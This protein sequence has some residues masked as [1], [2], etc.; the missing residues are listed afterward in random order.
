MRTIVTIVVALFAVVGM[1]FFT[2]FLPYVALFLA[3]AVVVLL[4]AI[5]LAGYYIF[6]KMVDA[7]L[8]WT[9]VETGWCKIILKW[10]DYKRTIGPGL[11]FIGI[12]GIYTLYRR[13][14]TFLKSV[15]DKEGRPQAE[16]HEDRDISSFKTTDYAYAFPFKDE[17]DS[18]GLHLSGM[19]AVIAILEDYWKAFFVAS[20]W[21]SI[22]NSEIM[23]C[24]RDVLVEI[25][26]DDELVGRDTSEERDRKT[27]SERLWTAMNHRK[28]GELSVVEK[29]R[30]LYGIWVKSTELRSVDPPE[31]WR[32]TTLAPYKAEREKQA[33]KHQAEA[34]AILFDDTN[35]A[36][37]AWIDGQ[38]TAGYEPTQAQ[39]REK[40]EELRQRAL[41]KTSGY[42]QIHIKGLEGATTAVVGG[43]AGGTGILVGGGKPSGP[44][45]KKGGK[46]KKT[47][48]MTDDELARELD[49]TDD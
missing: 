38:K 43:G 24:F 10:G 12:P 13:K 15:T 16:P 11:H 3:L 28:G 14:M 44:S 25:S 32:D 26:Y 2:Y 40:Q 17:E 33:A 49:E 6:L 31:G 35:Q 20:D 7:N 36:L 5:G 48:D 23:P 22:M 34:S 39:I 8:F 21:Y 4:P 47:E 18:R 41:A 45:G 19:L 1:G 37:K 42:Q 9:R 27:F 46:R 29:L 30:N